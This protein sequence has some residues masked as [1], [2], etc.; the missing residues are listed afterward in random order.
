[1]ESNLINIESE[2]A[3]DESELLEAFN[4]L[5]KAREGASGQLEK[6]RAE[7]SRNQAAATLAHRLASIEV[8]AVDGAEVIADARHVREDAIRRRQDLH[9][10]LLD[11]RRSAEDRLHIVGKLLEQHQRALEELAR[12]NAAKAAAA[13]A[14]PPALP[15]PPALPLAKLAPPPAPT[16]VLSNGSALTVTPILLKNGIEARQHNRIQLMVQVDMTSEN[17]FYTGLSTNISAGGLFVAALD[18]LPFGTLIDL[19][20]AF[21]SSGKRLQVQGVVRWHREMD[22]RHPEVTPG[23][24]VEFINL[25]DEDRRAIEG[26]IAQRETFFFAEE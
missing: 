15:V 23:M 18:L 21:P 4:R 13:A 17:N 10:L 26:F 11:L 14:A 7:A 16:P 1:M 12:A 2:L 9:K 22:E 20:F 24:G 3:R 19:N 6:L 25:A 8:P 5:G